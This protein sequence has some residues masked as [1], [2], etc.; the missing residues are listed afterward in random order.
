M[1]NT[2]SNTTLNTT[3]SGNASAVNWPLVIRAVV[4]PAIVW[5]CIV[6]FATLGGYPG[7]ICITPMA[8]LVLPLWAGIFYAKG[9][10]AMPNATQSV[11]PGALV[12]GLLLGLI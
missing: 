4:A 2:T 11:L 12:V 1:N 8:I 5:A 6:G 9:R 7:V 10:S 3:S